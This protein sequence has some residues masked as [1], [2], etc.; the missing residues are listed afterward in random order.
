MRDL[1]L[2]PLHIVLFPGMP[3][4]LHIFEE[5]YKLMVQHCLESDRSF[6]VV[7]IRSGR[8][9]FGPAEPY[10]VGC[11]ARILEVETLDDGSMNL[12]ALGE[13]RFRILEFQPG[14]PYLHSQVE[15]L[16]LS[17]GRL[18][19]ALRGM[20]QFKHMVTNYM[21][22]M[23]SSG[24]VDLSALEWPDDPLM[25]IYLAASLLEVPLRE[26]QM[27]LEMDGVGGVFVEVER[28]YR[29]ELALLTLE[30]NKRVS[31]ASLN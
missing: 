27:L 5:R 9:V 14:Q 26:K 31:K 1:P 2:F 7:L 17:T 23:H 8:E 29:R 13:E 6:G 15:C 18:L 21:R 12:T 3:I 24:A 25:M 19:E 30:K 28:L 16:P 20:G 22:Q 4:H 11:A 10:P